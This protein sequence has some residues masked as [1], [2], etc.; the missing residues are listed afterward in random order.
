MGA[1]NAAQRSRASSQLVHSGKVYRAVRCQCIVFVF[2]KYCFCAK[3]GFKGE[4]GIHMGWELAL[5]SILLNKSV[6]ALLHQCVSKQQE[7]CTNVAN[8]RG[9]TSDSSST[10]LE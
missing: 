2:V 7:Q 1:C 8:I 5:F 6:G 3:H 4:G 10:A 9:V